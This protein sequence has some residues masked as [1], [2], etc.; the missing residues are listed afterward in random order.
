MDSSLFSAASRRRTRTPSAARPAPK[1]P[2]TPSGIA[3]RTPYRHEESRTEPR[4]GLRPGRGRRAQ[5]QTLPELGSSVARGVGAAANAR[6]SAATADLTSAPI[7]AAQTAVGRPRGPDQAPQRTPTPRSQ[8]HRGK[9]FPH[10]S[11]SHQRA[12]TRRQHPAGHRKTPGNP[13][14][15]TNR[16]GTNARNSSPAN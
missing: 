15:G 7:R 14:S 1:C 12:R 5:N 9:R 2:A 4:S 11:T 3:I 16:R 13:T 6:Q 10:H 8:A